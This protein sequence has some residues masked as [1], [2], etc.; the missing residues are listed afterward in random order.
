MSEP[1]LK[2]VPKNHVSDVVE[3]LEDLLK[4]AKD[5]EINSVIVYADGPKTYSVNWA[6][7]ADIPKIVGHLEVTKA[8]LLSRLTDQL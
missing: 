6:G 1:V 4:R 5:G 8:H 2:I 7:I 3:I